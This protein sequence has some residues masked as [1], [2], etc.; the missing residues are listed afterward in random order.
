[1][2]SRIK[3]CRVLML[4]PLLAIALLPLQARAQGATRTVSGT[5]L[6]E[7]SE[8]LI[9]ASVIAQGSTTGAATDFDGK[10]KITVS[11]NVKNLEITYVGYEKAVVAIPAS[12]NL[13][14]KLKPNAQVMEEVVVIGYG[15][16]KKDD[17]TGSI[18][19]VGEKDFNQGLISSPEQLVNGKVAGVQ[20]VNSGGSP[21]AGST[22]RIRG[23]ASLT[24]SNDPLIVLDGVPMEVGGS[25]SG[26]GNFLSLINPNDIESMTVLK[27]ASSTAIYGSRASNGVIIITTKKGSGNDRIKVNFQTT[28]SLQ[29]RTKVADMLGAAEMAAIVNELGTDKQKA[30]VNT[31]VNTDWNDEIYK[32]AFGTDNNLSVAGRVTKD[33]PFR[34]SLGYYNQDGILKTDNATRYTGSISLSPSFFNNYLRLNI[35]GKGTINQ[36]RF[37]NTSAI[38]GGATHSP[39]S[40]IYDS[41]TN[42]P[43]GGYYEAHDANYVPITGATGNPVGLLMNRK[44]TSK[45][46]RLIGNIDVDYRMHFL[47]DLRFHATAGYDFSQGKGE[48]YV[49][50]SAFQYYNSK[51]RDYSYGPQKNHNKLLTLYLNYNKEFKEIKSTLDVTAGYDYQ[52]WKYTNA[53]FTEL[54]VD[55][56]VQNTSAAADQRHALISYYGRVNYSFDSRYLL[57]AT[58]RR[59][60]SSRFSPDTRWGTFPSVALAWRLSN[61]AFFEPV[62]KVMNDFKIRLSYGVTGQQDGIANYS[63]MPIYTISQNGANYMFGGSPI[64]TYRPAA[65]NANLKWETTKAYNAGFDFA[66]LNN[67]ITGTFDY[68]NRK[69]EDLLATVP[70]AAGTNFDKQLLTNVGN[71]KSSGVEI[72]I[73]ATPIQTKDFTWSL[74]ANATWQKNEITNL[75]LNKDAESPN[76][77]VGAIESHYVQVLSEGYAPY[78][79]YV[80]KQIYDEATGLPIEG[81]Y[82]DLNGDGVVDTKDKYSYHSPAPD[83]IFGL[84]TSLQWKKWT[85]S[86]SLRANVGNY[87]YNGM[88]MNTGAWETVFYNDYQLNRL[89]SSYNSTKFNTRQ[90]E[91]DHYVENASFLKMDNIQLGYNFG[92]ITKWCS[93]NV[94]AM[95][96][97]VFTVTNYTGVDPESQSGIDMTVYPRP[98]IYSLTIG[99]DF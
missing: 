7:T 11:Q 61:E 42:S 50:S 44:D 3:L 22:I 21:T 83:R 43:F 35:N 27:D 99:L 34:V 82:A 6:D 41:D 31:D 64:N 81:L 5:V 36:N 16:Q 93:L 77:L 10:F 30:L 32:T 56:N 92:K 57:T 8:P 73:S 13:E 75:K 45:V 4:L 96:Q 63:Y 66:F 87:L 76:T 67:R 80:Y 69:T 55:G 40:P 88:A 23:G 47:P 97:N 68:Y 70:S 52:F 17:L 53:A 39:F 25:V 95:V 65:Y 1:M 26:S 91:S 59:D 98:R 78:S 19:T 58:V 37:A 86:T 74:S 71:I 2:K 14:I 54:D 29:T 49:P 33:F 79:Y 20:I 84:S 24:A 89:N 72:A 51:G 28:N 46:Y 62:K 15:V 38:W 60:G 12:G 9:G 85:L 48:I 18:S 90:H 94:S